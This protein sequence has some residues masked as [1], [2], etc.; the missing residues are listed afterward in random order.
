MSERF[1]VATE[2]LVTVNEKGSFDATIQGTKILA[3]E[4]KNL[5]TSTKNYNT[6][7]Q[8]QAYLVRRLASDLRMLSIGL[9]VLKREYGGIN[10]VVDATIS[11]FSQ[12]S[13]AMSVVLGTASAVSNTYK[14]LGQATGTA[15]QGVTA[16]SSALMVAEAGLMAWAAAAVIAVGA[17]IAVGTAVFEQRSGITNLRTEIKGL[18]DDINALTSSMRNLN[19][20]QSAI[21]QTSSRNQA[22]IASLKREIE[23]TGDPT[24]ILAVRLKA[25]QSESADLA[26][27]SAWVSSQLAA[28][29]Y[30]MVKLKDTTA[31]YEEQIKKAS[32]AGYGALFAI[33]GGNPK[34]M[35]YGMMGAEG[36]SMGEIPK[37]QLG[38]LVRRSGVV[39]VEAGEVIMQKEQ[40][41]RMGAGG[42]GNQTVTISLA[43]A[44][45]Y[46]VQNLEE[47][48]RR[49]ANAAAKELER[50]RY[51]LRSRY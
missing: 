34:G 49:G 6:Q 2:I 46:G 33:A 32:D 50:A 9:S 21:N 26:V 48:M 36:A 39:S 25:A 47:A 30:Q 41:V 23:L 13:A 4:Q 44:N 45:I 16:L 15:G 31:D 35:P 14:L 37:Q 3:A 28:E 19:V 20:E 10:P 40:A 1:T 38:G 24:G 22:V 5:N 18:E 8:G 17:G 27:S 7:A 29:S 51:K 11:G 12:A 43:G 42:A